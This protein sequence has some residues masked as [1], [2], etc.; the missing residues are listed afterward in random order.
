MDQRGLRQ[1]SLTPDIAALHPGYL[2]H[3][4]VRD[5]G[6]VYLTRIPRALER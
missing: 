1:P 5:P 6:T 4:F 2:L 3:Y